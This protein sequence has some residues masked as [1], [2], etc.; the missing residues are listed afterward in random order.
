LLTQRFLVLLA[1]VVMPEEIVAITFT[2]KAAAEM[3]GRVL[4][5]L[6]LAEAPPATT[7]LGRTQQALACAVLARDT[8]CGWRL[9]QNPHRL[10]ILTIDALTG[11]L[12]R[13]LPLQSGLAPGCRLREDARELYRR[14]A[15]RTLLTAE[16]PDGAWG[17]ATRQVL[18]DLDNDWRRLEAL[19]IEMLGR[20]DQWLPLVAA[21][22]SRRHLEA[23]R[24]QLVAQALSQLVAMCPA[25]LKSQLIE[26]AR[27]IGQ[28]VAARTPEAPAALLAQFDGAPNDLAGWRCVADTLLTRTKPR[29]ARRKL[30]KVLAPGP[31][32]DRNAWRAAYQALVVACDAAPAWV[33][34]LDATRGL[35]ATRYSDREFARLC[36]LLTVLRLAAAQ[37]QV[38]SAEHATIDFTEQSLA[39]LAALGA[40][41]NPSDLALALDYQLSHLLVDEFQDT[42]RAQYLLLERL[43]AGWTGADQRTLFLVG[44]PMQS[45]YRFRDADVNLFRLTLARLQFGNIPLQGLRL[46][47][48]F[49]TAPRVLHWLNTTLAEVFAATDRALPPFHAF[50][51]TRDD[52]ALSQVQLHRATEQ[53]LA[54]QML[55]I[56]KATWRVAPTATIAILVRSRAHLGAV[57]QRLA[58]AGI[59]LAT[60]DIDALLEIPCINDLMALTRALYD[61]TD[62]TAWLGALRAPWCGLRL[63]DLRVLAGP[64]R[65]ALIWT[66]LNDPEVIAQLAPSEAARVMRVRDV[67]THVLAARARI[68]YARLVEYAWRWLEG[69]AALTNAQD[70]RY[71]LRYFELL[72]TLA[73]DEEPLT[74]PNLARHVAAEFAPFP[75][76]A[77]PVV[78]IM[79]I[80]HAKGLEFEVVLVPELQ[81]SGRVEPHTLLLGHAALSGADP[82]PVFAPCPPIGHDAATNA[83]AALYAYLRDCAKAALDAEGYRLLYVAL[84]RARSALH[85]FCTPPTMRDPRHGSF[86]GILWPAL[87]NHFSALAPPALSAPP[88]V[89]NPLRRRLALTALRAPPPGEPGI[90]TPRPP[91]P[92]EWAS[93]LAK[94]IGT[95]THAFLQA[96]ADGAGLALPPPGAI[97]ARLRALGLRGPEVAHATA[98]V[99]AAVAATLASPRG[100]WLFAPEH[101]EAGSE[102][103]ITTRRDARVVE[104]IVDR[105]FV[106]AAG[107]RWIVDFKTSTHEGGD[108]DAFMDSEVTRYRPQ[109]EAYARAFAAL[110]SAP[111]MLGL[112]YP[113]LDA[114]REWPAATVVS[115]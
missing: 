53:S 87:A 31:E 81:R 27:W 114:W 60:N 76:Q 13:R 90:S 54:D 97:R 49:R 77:G 5:V 56:I 36:S 33:A 28:S 103:R 64:R 51:A 115:H 75:R 47:A 88:A 35:P 6:A 30:G 108:R 71:A 18:S 44:D 93:P 101:R 24:A 66:R 59:P 23:A 85:L 74:G 109:L 105:T 78:E 22:P 61:L 26:M 46:N 32:S 41:D 57:P 104:L 25:T 82:L 83:D 67:L 4:A 106:T 107:V 2:R 37:W 20:R 11:S 40:A 7:E 8:A 113:R 63:I 112:Y 17:A 91:L 12:V 38:V 111:I 3:R 9:R 14:A 79:T 84:T 73:E 29:A 16:E 62:R 65:D 48:N 69:P 50:Q 1:R 92:F 70:L 34:A 52:D 21:A 94:P 43:T 72:E 95:V 68:P 80:H 96:L 15:R 42:S 99:Q 58:A 55:E 10:R 45:I 39:A 86:L 110:G 19:L 100:R 89:A 102:Y 98:E